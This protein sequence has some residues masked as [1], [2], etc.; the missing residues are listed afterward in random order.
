M[1]FNI[2]RAGLGRVPLDAKSLLRGVHR[3]H[4][5]VLKTPLRQPEFES[6]AHIFKRYCSRKVVAGS[7]FAIRSVGIVIAD[8]VTTA[9]IAIT[10]SMLGASY[11]PTP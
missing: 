6:S 11:T 5:G 4:S 7:V 8:I 9:R 3:A 1:E 2:A 10:L